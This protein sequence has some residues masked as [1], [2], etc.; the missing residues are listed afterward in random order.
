MSIQLSE[1]F[2]LFL[3]TLLV[4]PLPRISIPLTPFASLS[5][6][7]R[8]SMHFSLSLL[9]DRLITSI[10]ILLLLRVFAKFS[11]P[12]SEILFPCRLSSFSH[13]VWARFLLISL[14]LLSPIPLP[15][16]RSTPSVISVRKAAVI[17]DSLLT[18][19]PSF[20][21]PPRDFARFWGF[22]SIFSV[23]SKLIPLKLSCAWGLK[24][25]PGIALGLMLVGKFLGLI[26]CGLTMP[27]MPMLVSEI[28][29]FWLIL[30]ELF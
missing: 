17:A 2:S 3:L 14:M 11:T 22:Y 27:E 4:I 20:Y 10:W 9:F 7:A 16:R 21:V 1:F 15:L 25:V 18:F 13:W 26:L 30:A 6:A 19:L 12:L 28:W 5:T 24:A 29:R 23:G 8:G